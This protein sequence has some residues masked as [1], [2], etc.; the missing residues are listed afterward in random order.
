MKISEEFCGQGNGYSIS[1]TLRFELKPKGKTLENIEKEKLLESDFKKSQDYKDV[2]I[3]LDNYHKYFID[4]VLQKVNLDWTKLAA[5]ITDY[6]KNKEDDSSV[7]K[8]Q[9]F[10]RKEIVKI[11]SKDKR[12]ACLTAS[13]PKDLFNSILPEWFEKST[14]FSLNKK[15]VET[16]K[17]FSSYFKGFQENRKNMYKDEP[18]PTAVPYRIVNENF[19]KFLQNAESF[20]EI[21]KKCPEVIELVEKELSA[22]LGNDKLSDI[23]CVKNFN[24]YLCQTGAENQRGIDYYN[25]IIGGIVQKENDVKL[26]GINEFLNLFWQQHVDFAKDNRRIKFVPLYKQILSDRSSL[27]FKIQ[28]LESDEEL[29]EA[30]LSF[31]KKLDS[32]NKDGKNIFDLVMELTENIN[33]YDLS[34]IYINQKD[35]NAVSKTLTGDWAYLQKR[36]NIFAEETLTKSEQ[37]RWKKELDDDTS[38]SKGIFSFEEL[39]KVLEYSSENCSAVSIKIQE[40]FETTKRWYFE[41]QTGIFTKGEEIIEPSISGLCGQIKSNF[42]EV[43]KVFGNVSSEN[44]LRENPEEVE[45]I[46]NYLDSVQN[47]LHRIK[48][49][50]VNG[51]GDTSFYS[52][53]DEIYS[54][55]YEVISLYNKTR[56]YI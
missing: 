35:M 10:L 3:I 25:Q 36:M 2:K 11:I 49:L 34:Q 23:F 29:K 45:K 56:N 33:Q 52:E 15:A 27:S 40:Y 47:L 1:K 8:E 19:P 16:F 37:K 20:K 21:Q 14:E 17:R 18:I 32:K 51:I 6:N 31:A 39:N 50:K 13:T 7:I 30:V 42:D 9:D 54:V 44:T 48:P 4:D 41:K 22:Y 43:N 28:T 12:F 24:R 5:S 38:K 53:Y 26:R 46:K 55:L